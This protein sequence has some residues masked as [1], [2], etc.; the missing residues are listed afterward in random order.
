MTVKDLKELLNNYPD[1]IQV[2]VRGY[3]GGLDDVNP[4]EIVNV[5]LNYNNEWYYGKHEQ[6][7]EETEKTV[8]GV[9]L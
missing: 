5:E 1:D 2:F 4:G 9:V 7:S 8:K 6:I 3:E